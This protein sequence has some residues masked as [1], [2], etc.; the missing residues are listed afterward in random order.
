MFLTRA[1]SKWHLF[2][3][4]LLILFDVPV[5]AA[6]APTIHFFKYKETNGINMC[7]LHTLLYR[8]IYF[9]NTSDIYFASFCLFLQI[10]SKHWQLFLYRSPPDLWKSMK[11]AIIS[12]NHNLHFTLFLDLKTS[13]NTTTHSNL[14]ISNSSHK[15]Y[16][17]IHFFTSCRSFFHTF[18]SKPSSAVVLAKTT[19]IRYINQ[20][21]IPI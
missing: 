14:T 16:F 20:Y 8:Y 11:T 19:S 3:E 13:M 6:T 5:P 9:H 17:E 10:V 18:T 4:P 12:T 2:F 21:I 7:H 1:I 15:N